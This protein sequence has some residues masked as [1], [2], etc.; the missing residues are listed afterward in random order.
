MC[1]QGCLLFVA[2]IIFLKQFTF[3]LNFV[4]MC[5]CVCECDA[6][7]VQKRDPDLLELGL[8]AAVSCLV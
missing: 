7:R 8:R 6:R 3:T 2:F 4:Y 5:G 1:W